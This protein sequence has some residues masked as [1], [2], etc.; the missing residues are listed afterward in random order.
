LFARV[1]AEGSL[2]P[3]RTRVRAVTYQGAID[4]MLAELLV[5][6]PGTRC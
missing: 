6:G 4:A 5:H 3:A 2:A 1:I